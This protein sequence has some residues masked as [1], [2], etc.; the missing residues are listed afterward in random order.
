MSVP[1]YRNYNFEYGRGRCFKLNETFF[2]VEGE[3]AYRDQILKI[4]S[5]GLTRGGL[6]RSKRDLEEN[7]GLVLN[8][9]KLTRLKNA[10]R[11]AVGRFHKNDGKTTLILEFMRGFE[12]GAMHFRKVISETK[13]ITIKAVQQTDRMPGS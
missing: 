8:E 7:L 12:K 3:G 9:D 4:T 2:E 1:I 6:F 5:P 13:F 10:Y 11:S